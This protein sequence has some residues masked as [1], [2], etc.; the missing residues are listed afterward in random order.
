ME[1]RGV[2]ADMAG[3]TPAK[4]GRRGRPLEQLPNPALGGRASSAPPEGPSDPGKV[5]I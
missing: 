4:K 3:Q 1:V 2:S 5:P